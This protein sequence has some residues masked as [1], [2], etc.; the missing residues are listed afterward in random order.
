MVSRTYNTD[1]PFGDWDRYSAERESY[2]SRLPT[3]DIC[4]EHIDE[5]YDLPGGLRIC[6]ECLKEYEA[7]YEPEE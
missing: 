3:C 1:D 6:P 4:G 5:G 2:T 7:T